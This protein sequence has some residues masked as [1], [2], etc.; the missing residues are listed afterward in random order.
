MEAPHPS[1]WFS[2]TESSST[3]ACTTVN[4]Q[5]TPT[6]PSPP[7][8]PQP[9]S[10]SPPRRT[11][12]EVLE[13][14]NAAIE[15]LK[16]NGFHVAITQQNWLRTECNVRN[17][18][19]EVDTITALPF[20][21]LVDGRIIG[22]KSN[23]TW[24]HFEKLNNHGKVQVRETDK[25][26]FVNKW[27]QEFNQ[28]ANLVAIEQKYKTTL[29]CEVR[30]IVSKYVILDVDSWSNPT[31]LTLHDIFNRHDVFPPNLKSTPF[32]LSRSKALTHFYFK[33]ED[34][35]EWLYAKFCARGK[36]VDVFAGFTGDL[37]FNHS[38]EY[39]GADMFAHDTQHISSWYE[40]V[41]F[42]KPEAELK[43][44]DKLLH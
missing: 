23:L 43:G 28:T 27:Y 36:A 20:Q 41:P 44:V 1:T 14:R 18:L 13:K 39:A 30:L 21:Q 15:W 35:P 32:T 12:Q 24:D 8:R 4:S 11:T 42:L 9:P 31:P 25:Y 38:W 40:I 34:M 2:T 37:L 16:S 6:R 3:A 19:T 10:F 5:S 33:F 29:Y 26:P 22:A 7:P 17:K